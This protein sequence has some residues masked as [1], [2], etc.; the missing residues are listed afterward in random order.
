MYQDNPDQE[1]N[2]DHETDDKG[3][4]IIAGLEVP[5][6]VATGIEAETDSDGEESD[7]E[8]SDTSSFPEKGIVSSVGDTKTRKKTA[9]MKKEDELDIVPISTGKSVSSKQKIQSS[10]KP[11]AMQ[12]RHDKPR[13]KSWVHKIGDFFE[14]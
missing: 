10:V 3:I 12:P 8:S 13:K 7:D 1:S 5:S 9:S 6:G 2:S 11:E 4:P 14:S